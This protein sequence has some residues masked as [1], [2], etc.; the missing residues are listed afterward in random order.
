[1]CPCLFVLAQDTKENCSQNGEP[2]GTFSATGE[3]GNDLSG[4]SWLSRSQ[5]VLGLRTHLQEALPHLPGLLPPLP[6]FLRCLK[7]LPKR[8]AL[9]KAEAG[10]RLINFPS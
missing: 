5:Q 4:P 9:R 3:G 8:P 1:M 2:L 6:L 7:H 10:R